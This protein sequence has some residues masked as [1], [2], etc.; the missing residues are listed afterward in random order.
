M[1]GMECKQ[2]RECRAHNRKHGQKIPIIA[3][4]SVMTDGKGNLLS[5]SNL[6]GDMGMHESPYGAGS[7][8]PC[9]NGRN[10][11]AISISSSKKESTLHY[12]MIANRN[13]LALVLN[14]ISV[15]KFGS[16][17]SMNYLSSK[18]NTDT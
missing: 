17:V 10:G 11:N 3:K 4:K 14:G 13:L 18:E 9:Q 2:F 12:L 8:S 16:S 1:V 6:C 15:A 5:S 7:I